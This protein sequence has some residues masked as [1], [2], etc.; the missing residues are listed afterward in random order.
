MEQFII[1]F[2]EIISGL[3]IVVFLAITWK[4]EIGADDDHVQ[5]RRTLG[6]HDTVG[7][8]S[9]ACRLHA[10]VVERHDELLQSRD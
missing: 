3:L 2:W 4:A 1:N 7:T 10:T 5:A 9:R 8:G 6:A